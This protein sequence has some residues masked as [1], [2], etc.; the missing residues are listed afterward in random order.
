[1][2]Q[3]SSRMSSRTPATSTLEQGRDAAD[4]LLHQ[5]VRTR[6]FERMLAQ[7]GHGS[8]L[9]GAAGELRLGLLLLADVGQDAVP[10][11]DAVAVAHE[12][13]IV[14]DPHEVAVAVEHPVLDRAFVRRPSD[15]LD[16]DLDHAVAVVR[17]QSLCPEPSVAKPFLGRVAED[18][19]DLGAD[20][21]PQP[22]VT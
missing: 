10:A 15:V 3:W 14:A 20:V 21:M 6:P 4:D 16:L 1:M 13:G 2:K 11:L 12:H 8:L 9:G 18:R 7:T 17:V 19:L 5:L 22:V